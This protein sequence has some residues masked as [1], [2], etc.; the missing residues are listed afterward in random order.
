MESSINDPY[1][2][3]HLDLLGPVNVISIGKKRYTLVTVD[4]FY[5]FTWVYFLHRKEETPEILLNHVNM[6]ED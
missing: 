1:H 4:E 6:I 2:M 5:R 3:L